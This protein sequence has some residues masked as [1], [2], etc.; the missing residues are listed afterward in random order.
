MTR[1]SVLVDLQTS[2]D[3]GFCSGT[4]PPSSQQNSVPVDEGA[5]GRCGFTDFHVSKWIPMK[6]GKHAGSHGAARAFVCNHKEKGK[7][8]VAQGKKSDNPAPP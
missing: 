3:L 6:H 5:T 1:D 4:S 2:E 8:L 7:F